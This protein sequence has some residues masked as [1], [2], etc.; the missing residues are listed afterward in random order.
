MITS[1]SW[2]I[3]V[4]SRDYPPMYITP[5]SC[6]ISLSEEAINWCGNVWLILHQPGS[7]CL[8]KFLRLYLATEA[9]LH[10][11][12]S[13]WGI[14][15]CAFV[16]VCVLSTSVGWSQGRVFCVAQ[17]AAEAAEQCAYVDEEGGHV[18][19]LWPH[20]QWVLTAHVLWNLLMNILSNSSL[21]GTWRVCSQLV[22]QC[23]LCFFSPLCPHPHMHTLTLWPDLIIIVNGLIL[24][25]YAATIECKLMHAHLHACTWQQSWTSWAL[26]PSFIV[27]TYTFAPLCPLPRNLHYL[28]PLSPSLPLILSPLHP[29]P[30]AVEGNETVQ[31]YT[32]RHRNHDWLST[33]S[34]FF[35]VCKWWEVFAY[36]CACIYYIK[37]TVCVCVC[38]CSQTPPKLCQRTPPNLR[39]FW[40]TAWKVS[41]AGQRSPSHHVLAVSFH[42]CIFLRGRQPH[43]GGSMFSVYLSLSIAI[44]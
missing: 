23:V 44:I 5:H 43:Y 29:A 10:Y 20:C 12:H 27:S 3:S 7:C 15:M 2:L 38:V 40:R 1:C 39:G 16:H 18:A 36:V 8:A 24:W 6:V 34:I 31:D 41:S 9:S 22:L 26:P 33:I 14:C 35:T 42:F 28:L 17:E 19:V 37:L 30:S 4:S 25:G 21:N 32:I 11:F 13:I